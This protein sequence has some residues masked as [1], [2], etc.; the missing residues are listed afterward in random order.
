M[1][2]IQFCLN[3]IQKNKKQTKTGKVKRIEIINLLTGRRKKNLK[4]KKIEKKN[5]PKE[6]WVIWTCPDLFPKM[7]RS[8]WFARFSPPPQFFSG[9][10]EGARGQG[11]KRRGVFFCRLWNE[12]SGP[13]GGNMM[14]IIY[15]LSSSY[16]VLMLSHI[17]EPLL[18]PSGSL[19]ETAKENDTSFE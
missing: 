11:K 5:S 16:L 3:F 13:L 8:R 7:F 6:S 10:N 2:F 14:I 12:N 19:C 15:F 1:F 9:K 17:Q 18:G 4:N